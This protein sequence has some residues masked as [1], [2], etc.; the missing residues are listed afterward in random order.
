MKDTVE[1]FKTGQVTVGTTAVKVVSS[2]LPD[3]NKKGILIKAHGSGDAAANTVPIFLGD[4]NV[5]TSSG[6]SLAPGESI[7]IPISGDDLY[8]VASAASQKLSRMVV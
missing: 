4:A 3:G 5:T 8:A 7:T 2:N 6:F 1:Y